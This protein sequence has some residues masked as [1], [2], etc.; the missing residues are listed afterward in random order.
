MKID[1][2]IIPQWR[3]GP[4]MPRVRSFKT[5]PKL[6]NHDEARCVLPTGSGSA[7]RLQLKIRI[8]RLRILNR[9]RSFDANFPQK[10][11]RREVAPYF[12]KLCVAAVSNRQFQLVP[13]LTVRLFVLDSC[14]QLLQHSQHILA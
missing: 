4:E 7:I 3:V 11:E 8:L 12:F 10:L 13:K 2:R 9:K 1:L 6:E 14:A 5:R